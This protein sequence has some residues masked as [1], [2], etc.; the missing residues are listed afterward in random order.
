MASGNKASKAGVSRVRSGKGHCR[1]EEV[2]AGIG[3]D[4]AKLKAV[5]VEFEASR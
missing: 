2:M 5:T 1:A 4:A 3:V